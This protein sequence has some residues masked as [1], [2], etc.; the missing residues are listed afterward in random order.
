MHFQ[1]FVNEPAGPAF[2]RNIERH[3]ANCGKKILK[4][5]PPP[6]QISGGSIRLVQLGLPQ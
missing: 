2:L 3:E 6:R 4:G 5:E 1:R